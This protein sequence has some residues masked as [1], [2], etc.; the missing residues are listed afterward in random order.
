[1]DRGAAIS[2]ANAQE[3]IATLVDRAVRDGTDADE[4]LDRAVAN[5]ESL[6]LDM[7]DLTIDDA[8]QAGACAPLQRSHNLGTGDR[9]CLALGKRM[10]LPVVHAVQ[11]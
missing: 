5:L 3:V 6:V 7:D 4:A 2:T 9:F 10:G 8:M 1:M 11:M